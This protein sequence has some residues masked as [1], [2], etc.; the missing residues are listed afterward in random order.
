MTLRLALLLKEAYA[1]IGTEIRAYIGRRIPFDDLAPL[2]DRKRLM[3][4]LRVRTHAL[5]AEAEP[6]TDEP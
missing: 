4:S 3:E 1:R 5:A 2:R 6:R